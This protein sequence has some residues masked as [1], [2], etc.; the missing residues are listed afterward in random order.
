MLGLLFFGV[1]YM[2]FMIGVCIVAPFFSY[3]NLSDSQKEYGKVQGYFLLKM[4][5]IFKPT[6]ITILLFLLSMGIWEI[7]WHLFAYFP[8]NM[9]KIIYMTS[10]VLGVVGLFYILHFTKKLFNKIYSHKLEHHPVLKVIAIEMNRDGI[11]LVSILIYFAYVVVAP[12][13]MAMDDFMHTSD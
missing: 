2:A 4:W 10:A 8:K 3:L 9:A 12:G 13:M 1:F 6:V 5:F 11:F 7:I